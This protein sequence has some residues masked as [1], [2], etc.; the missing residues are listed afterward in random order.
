MEESFTQDEDGRI[1]GMDFIKPAIQAIYSHMLDMRPTSNIIKY[2]AKESEVK[3]HLKKCPQR[4]RWK[5]ML[6]WC[7][8]EWRE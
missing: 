3:T 4:P 2:A 1:N 5:P 7:H 8:N 6:Q